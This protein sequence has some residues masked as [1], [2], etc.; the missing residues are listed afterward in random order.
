M[1]NPPNKT[2]SKIMH[3]YRDYSYWISLLDDCGRLEP[4]FKEN[5]IETKEFPLESF[6]F[7]PRFDEPIKIFVNDRFVFNVPLTYITNSSIIQK[8][9]Y[10]R[11]D[12]AYIFKPHLSSQDYKLIESFIKNPTIDKAEKQQALAFLFMVGNRKDNAFLLSLEKQ[13]EFYKRIQLFAQQQR[14][15]EYFSHSNID[16]LESLKYAFY[17]RQAMILQNIS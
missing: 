11:N 9:L 8:M 1:Y 15:F 12:N 10:L 13:E 16:F 14:I 7:A 3:G 2:L 4:V 5:A 17:P 6:A